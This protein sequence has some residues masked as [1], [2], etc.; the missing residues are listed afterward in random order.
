MRIRIVIARCGLRGTLRRRKIVVGSLVLRENGQH[1][2]S[3]L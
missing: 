3:F 2:L 1:L